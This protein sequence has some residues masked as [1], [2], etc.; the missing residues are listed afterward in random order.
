MAEAQLNCQIVR[1][2]RLLYEGPIGHV[3]LVSYT[4]EVG[5][6]PGHAAEILALGDGVMRI[7][8]RKQDGGDLRRIVIS[9]G[10]AEISNDTVIV[11]ADHARDIDDIEPEVVNET[12]Q[13][14]IDAR[15]ALPED[16]HR[17]AYYQNKIKWCDLLL[18]QVKTTSTAQKRN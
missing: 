8:R 10:Y 9:G 11:L 16:D 15:N 7:T 14:A 12:K 17:R 3:V 5:V 1:P 2:D 6:W 18:K 13:K 4:G